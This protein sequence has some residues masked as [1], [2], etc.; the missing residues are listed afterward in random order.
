MQII[1]LGGEGSTV[2]GWGNATGKGRNH[3]RVLLKL[4]PAGDLWEGCRKCASEFSHLRVTKLKRLYSKPS[5]FGVEDCWG[6]LI[7]Q[8]FQPATLVAK[9]ALKCWWV[10]GAPGWRNWSSD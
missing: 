10:S 1:E 3:Y 4:K 2:E 5:Q 7:S 9:W 6:S 8:H